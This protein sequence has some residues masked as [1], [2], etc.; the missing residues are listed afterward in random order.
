M[1]IIA[2]THCFYFHSGKSKISAWQ[3]SQNCIE[4]F[5]LLDR[6]PEFTGIVG[7]AVKFYLD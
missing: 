3:Y 5:L 4:C 6:C 7:E 1:Q 2:R